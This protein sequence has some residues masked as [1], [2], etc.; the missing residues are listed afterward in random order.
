MSKVLDIV[1][2]NNLELDFKVNKENSERLKNDYH[3]IIESREMEIRKL[4][5]L[6]NEDRKVRRLE[7]VLLEIENELQVV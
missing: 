4:H 7:F 3:L 5:L 1:I 2:R 6:K